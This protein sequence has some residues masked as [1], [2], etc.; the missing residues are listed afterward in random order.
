MRL[1]VV[2]VNGDGGRDNEERRDEISERR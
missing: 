2:K 1:E